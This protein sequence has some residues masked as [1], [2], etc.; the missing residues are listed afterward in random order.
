MKTLTYQ[1]TI[2][3][4]DV[5]EVSI[6]GPTEGNP[7][8]EQWIKARFSNDIETKEV[9][10]F[11]DG[12]GLYK[13]RFMP[14]FEGVYTFQITA[15]FIAETEKGTFT[16]S[17]AKKENHGPVR[18]A[19]TYHFEYEDGSVYQPIGTTCYVWELQ[20]ETLQKQT[21]QSLKKS[22][23]NK[24][25]FCIFPKHYDYN[26][27]EPISYPYEGTPC[28]S[29]VITKE[30]FGQFNGRA[31]GNDWD[32]F[33][34][35]PIH[36]R[37]IEKNICSLG[38]IGIEADIIVMHPYDRWGFSL[39]NKEE[40][41]LYW[42]YVIARFAAY[43]NVWWS[44]AN[45]YDL[46][47]AKTT[48]DWENY[49]SIICKNDPYQHLRSIHNCR[50]F[51]DYTRPWVTHCSIQRINTYMTAENTDSWKQ[52]FQKPIVL[53]EITYEG[54]IQH[55]WGNISGKEM[56]RRFW[57]AALRGG[58]PGHSETYLSPDNILW[59]S[60]GGKLKGE[61]PERIA[62]LKSIMYQTPGYGLTRLEL[63]WDDLCAIADNNQ[64]KSLKVQ[65]YYLFYYGINRPSFR[66]FHFDETTAF[67]VEVID[68]WEMKITK[69][70]T[71]TGNFKIELPGKEYMAIRLRK[72]STC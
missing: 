60:H 63:N 34:F 20:N 32:Y 47:S 28:D 1:K 38:E 25:R 71:Y 55:G 4:W 57:E 40:D 22:P 67:D 65:P 62:F 29:S 70:G 51:Y 45:E 23:F 39:M 56:T 13:A 58:Y 7:F 41:A 17:Q 27:N 19:H 46:M 54:N 11:Y 49:A 42:H 68:T 64:T 24:I 10:G 2:S 9:E 48:E 30:N 44:L 14:S 6:K 43:H 16:V 61:S 5:F 69:V 33:R 52:R 21:L 72:S 3:K 66:T 53:D 18:V 37:N 15:S 59:W 50:A 35:N 36:F 31:K 26:F 12:E 8:T